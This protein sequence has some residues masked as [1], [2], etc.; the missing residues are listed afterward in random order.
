[1]ELRTRKAASVP[2]TSEQVTPKPIT[3]NK[4]QTDKSEIAAVTPALAPAPAPELAAESSSSSSSSSSSYTACAP[5]RKLKASI[6]SVSETYLF[7]IAAYLDAHSIVS[8][9]TA[10]KIMYDSFRR[11]YMFYISSQSTSHITFS[12]ISDAHVKRAAQSYHNHNA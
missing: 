10:S 1:M 4:K 9:M 11:Y 7:L 3:K 5:R 8:L 12:A 2:Q 6:S